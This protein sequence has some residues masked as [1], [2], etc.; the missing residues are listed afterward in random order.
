MK[1]KARTTLYD[2]RSLARHAEPLA[3]WMPT[4]IENIRGTVKRD[5]LTAREIQDCYSN[6]R[7]DTH[8]AIKRRDEGK[9]P[10]H[11]D[12]M[13][14]TGIRP[15]P[16]AGEDW[17]REGDRVACRHQ[18]AIVIGVERHGYYEE[19]PQGEPRFI[20]LRYDP[21]DG[22]AGVVDLVPAAIVRRA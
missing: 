18:L 10:T 1:T 15:R 16:F 19:R 14:A 3:P 12:I 4:R 5:D 17:F 8:I 11:T 22:G 9:P 2:L 20:R 13:D 6:L 21:T 7:L